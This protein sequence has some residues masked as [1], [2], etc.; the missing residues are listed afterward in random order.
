MLSQKTDE[1]V[2]SPTKI[3]TVYMIL[4]EYY[5]LKER[6][7]RKDMSWITM[8]SHSLLLM[9]LAASNRDSLVLNKQVFQFIRRREQQS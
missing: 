5:H 6:M 2:Q 3:Y 8:T 7:G 1:Q 4:T 9:I